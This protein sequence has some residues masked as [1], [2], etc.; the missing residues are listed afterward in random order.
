MS[1]RR[2]AVLCCA[3]LAATACKSRPA[4]TRA[5]AASLAPPPDVDSTTLLGGERG[6]DHVGVAVKDLA[7]ATHVYH[8]LLGFNRPTEGK[9]PNGIRNV[10]YYFTDSTYLE[11]L[12]HWDRDRA[13]WL[14][15]FTDKH[16][17]ALFAVLSARSPEGTTAFLA[18]RGIRVGAP[19]SGSIEVTGEPGGAPRRE[20]WQTLFLPNG[21]LPGDPLYFIS[22]PR[23]PR[24]EFLRKL[25]S[26]EARRLF[27]HDNTALGLRAIWIAVPDIA[28]AARGYESIGLARRSR[29]SD[30][31]LGAGVQVFEAGAGEIWLV[32]PEAHEGK[33]N[34]FLEERG[35]PGIIGMTLMAG[36][37]PAAHRLITER[38]NRS[39]PRFEG[40]Y[41]DSFRLP[42]DMT[43]GVWIEFAQHLVPPAAK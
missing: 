25:G 31:S 43:L 18:A 2:T 33:V 9:L 38:T 24:Q 40:P 37:I 6:L 41:G 19:Y 23:A 39:L 15:S 3:L 34:D 30:A 32:Q 12:V 36:S 26:R 14:A 28:E 35:G 11:T 29:F 17:G 10:N 22:Y 16:S 21:L 1:A 27:Y 5:P 4:D 20:T 42:P 8:D 13:P 7:A